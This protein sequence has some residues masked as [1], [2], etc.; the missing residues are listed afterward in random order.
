MKL[1][2]P[3]KA[4]LLNSLALILIGI[5]GYLIKSSPTHVLLGTTNVTSSTASVTFASNIDS[6]YKNYLFTYTRINL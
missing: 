1:I 3:K 2:H 5:S 4:T 6:T